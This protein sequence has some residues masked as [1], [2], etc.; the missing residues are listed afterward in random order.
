MEKARVYFTKEI[1]KEALVRMYEVLGRELKGKVAVKISTGEPGGHNF[2]NPNL[3]KDLVQKLEGTI[4]ECNTAYNGRRNTTEEHLK[5]VQEHG[6]TEICNVD[7]MDSNGDMAIPVSAIRDYI[8]NAIDII[9]NV[10]RLSDG[11]RKVTSINEV[12]GTLNGEINIKK[13]FGF[14]QIGLTSSGEVDGEYYIE[15]YLPKG[16]DE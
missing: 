3:I 14:K 7:I 12:V 9:V 5:A 10:E 15:K 4:V 11:R 13:I 16:R 6:F 1:T 2:L 8:G